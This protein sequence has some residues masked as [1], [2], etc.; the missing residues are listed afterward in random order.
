MLGIV[1][2][3]YREFERR[4]DLLVNRDLSKTERIREIIKGRIG[5]I[6]KAEIMKECPDISQVT[7]QRALAEL[8]KEERIIKIGGGRYTKYIW[9]YDKE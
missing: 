7:V 6:T 3:A 2:A 9:N 4:T 8:L 1:V 5:P